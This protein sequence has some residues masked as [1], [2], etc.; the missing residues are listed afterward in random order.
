MNLNTLLQTLERTPERVEFEDTLAVID[1]LYDFAPTAFRNG[2]IVN[3]AGQNSG[4]CR[5]FAFAKLHGLTEQQTLACFGRHYRDVLN[6]PEGDD[7]QNIRNFMRHGRT[8]IHFDAMP[9]TLKAQE[10]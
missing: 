7:H 6:N 4:S 1:A 2:D 3:T 5:L 10:I 8:R 9:L